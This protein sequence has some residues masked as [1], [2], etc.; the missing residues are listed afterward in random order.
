L[1]LIVTCPRHFEQDA[2]G[3]IGSLFERMGF[4][5][6]DTS[7]TDMP[8]ILAVRTGHDPAEIVKKVSGIIEDEPWLIRY[9]KRIIPVH[10]TSVSGI[11]EIV[12]NV[13]KAKS[14]IGE[15]QTYR[16]TVEKRHSGLSSRE[17]IAEIAGVIP[18]GVSLENPD[19]VV[20]VEILG[21][22]AGV[23]VVR[24]HEIVS[25]EKRKRSLSEED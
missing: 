20:L 10:R 4:E 5:A 6:P 22:V 15:G 21:A 9:S 2:A 24:P 25:V 23:A 14:A 12:A 11:R 13:E 17:L 1:D 19:W 16:I 3:E 8:G 7:V 18:N